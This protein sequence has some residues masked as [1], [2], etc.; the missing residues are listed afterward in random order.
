MVLDVDGSSSDSEYLPG[1]S[2]GSDEDDE[3]ISIKKAIQGVQEKVEVR[4]ISGPR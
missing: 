2:E 3:A 4:Q 1:D